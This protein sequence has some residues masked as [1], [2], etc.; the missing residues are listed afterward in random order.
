MSA[1][2]QKQTIRHRPCTLRLHVCCCHGLCARNTLMFYVFIFAFGTVLTP[3]HFQS[4]DTHLLAF[5]HL[6]CLI[7]FLAESLS[8]KMKSTN[9]LKGVFFFSPSL[10]SVETCCRRCPSTCLTCHSKCWLSATTSWCLY[11]RRSASPHTS[12][13]WWAEWKPLETVCSVSPLLV[14]CT[15]HS[16]TA[17][18]IFHIYWLHLCCWQR[19]T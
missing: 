2:W 17:V 16:F 3:S 10:F 9:K 13:S 15:T 5:S 4:T 19:V 14:L 8:D 1:G 18:L 11:L 12:C 7:S 6:S